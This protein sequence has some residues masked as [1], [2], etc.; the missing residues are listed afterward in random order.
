MRAAL[1]RIKGFLFPGER[2]FAQIITR[3]KRL[4]SEGWAYF[5]L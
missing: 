5:R 3:A 4:E 1:E 2:S